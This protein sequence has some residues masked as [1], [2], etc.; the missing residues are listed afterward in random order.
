M[1]DGTSVL[2]A[3]TLSTG[4]FEFTLKEF[5]ENY[6]NVEWLNNH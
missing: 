4:T 2:E 5:L 3:I 6:R 1:D